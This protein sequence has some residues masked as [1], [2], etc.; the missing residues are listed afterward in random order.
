ME[1]MDGQV[2]DDPAL[3]FIP[4]HR[5][6]DYYREVTSFLFLFVFLFLKTRTTT[7]RWAANAI[8]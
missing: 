1:F 5:R 3:P 6:A 7:G 4:R 2:F 8:P